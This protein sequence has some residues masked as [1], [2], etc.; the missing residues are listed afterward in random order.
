MMA[1]GAFNR[2]RL[3]PQVEVGEAGAR[4]RFLHV[5]RFDSLLFLAI[6]VIAVVLGMQMPPAHAE[7][8]VAL[9]SLEGLFLAHQAS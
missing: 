9:R 4:E 8:E 2:F 1:L 6:L 3:V 5:L 7:D